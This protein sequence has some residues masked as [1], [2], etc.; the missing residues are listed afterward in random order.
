MFHRSDD[1]SLYR[2]ELLTIYRCPAKER[3]GI[4][5]EHPQA[6]M[7]VCYVGHWSKGMQRFR[8][9]GRVLMTAFH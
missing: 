5:K 4:Q 2:E 1:R 3:F 9:I 8:S 6:E 7:L